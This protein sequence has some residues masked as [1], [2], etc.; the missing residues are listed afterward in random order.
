MHNAELL[1]LS[2]IF[3]AGFSGQDP[4]GARV[5]HSVIPGNR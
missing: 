1:I 3:V 2:A 5:M 4:K